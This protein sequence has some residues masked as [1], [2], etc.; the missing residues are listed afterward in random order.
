MMMMKM[1]VN[2]EDNGDVFLIIVIFFVVDYTIH[3]FAWWYCRRCWVQMSVVVTVDMI[4]MMMMM[5]D[6]DDDDDD[7]N[8]NNNNC[9][10]RRFWVQRIYRKWLLIWYR[11]LYTLYYIAIM[12]EEQ[13]LKALLALEKVLSSSFI[14]H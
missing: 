9:R 5:F 4:Q 10:Y 13:R 12:D 11:L 7:D 14:S 1:I 8:N 6:D 2:D 3:A